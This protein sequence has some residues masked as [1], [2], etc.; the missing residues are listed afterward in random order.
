[1]RG[2][3]LP[4]A[5][6]APRAALLLAAVV[7]SA[8]GALSALVSSDAR[9]GAPAPPSLS[10]RLGARTYALA[11]PTGWLAAPIPGLREDDVVDLLGTRSGERATASGVAS[12]LRVM[13][14]DERTVVVELTADDASAIAAARARGLSLIPILRSLR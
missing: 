8:A 2:L 4:R 13:S 12:G 5:A 10:Q 3:A 6:L 7:L 9:S 11:L 1:M 14:V